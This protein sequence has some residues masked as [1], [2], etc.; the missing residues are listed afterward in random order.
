MLTLHDIDAAFSLIFIS[1][2]L[3]L[4]LLPRAAEELAADC[5]YGP[6]VKLGRTHASPWPP[7][8]LIHYALDRREHTLIYDA[9]KELRQPSPTRQ[10]PHM[11][12]ALLYYDKSGDMPARAPMISARRIKSGYHMT[13]LGRKQALA[14]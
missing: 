9:R 3:F 12:Q 13:I 10:M 11:P 2:R 14:R 4:E 7:P 1:G 8:R 6:F 5:Q